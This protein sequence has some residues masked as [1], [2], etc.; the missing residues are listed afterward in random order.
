[1][2]S[3]VVTGITY[4]LDEA[5]VTIH[6]L[7]AKIGSLSMIFDKLSEENIFVDMI[8]QTGTS[9][10]ATNLSFTVPDE[11]SSRALEI[12]QACVPLLKAEGALLERDI[13]KVS[14]VG[15][16]MRY[17]TGV[18]ANMFKA[19]A[20]EEIDV[21]MISTSEIKISV[22]IPRK[23]CEIAVRTLHEAFIEFKPETS[24]ESKGQE[25]KGREA[26]A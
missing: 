4:R 5:K 8:T 7:P 3:P 16:G 22:V 2:E 1:M 26:S 9:R 19:L 11:S 18:A 21:Q 12:A 24:Q 20:A 6:K 25:R 17:H 13:A 23:Y 10:G 14:V 15:A